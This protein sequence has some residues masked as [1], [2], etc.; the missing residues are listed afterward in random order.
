MDPA[1]QG[2]VGFGAFKLDARGGELRKGKQRLHLPPQPFKVLSLLVSRAGELV[3]REELQH[4]L[5]N[6]E[7]F[8]DFEQG[9]NVCIR[10]IRTVLND[11][12]EAPRFVET[13]PRRGYRFIGRHVRTYPRPAVINSVVVL[14]FE[15]CSED[16]ELDYL[17]QGIAESLINSLS[18]LPGL[19][20][21]SRGMAFRYKGASDLSTVRQELN[22][23]AVVTGKVI[24]QC[25]SIS[26]QAELTDLANQS[27]LWGGQYHRR[28]PAD[29]FK[30]Q[31]EISR[32]ICQGMRL[33]LSGDVKKRLRKRCT[34]DPEAYELYLK[35]RYC[36][37][38]R[39]AEELRKG[40][41]YFRKAIDRDPNYALAY[42]GLADS[43][44]LLGS[45]TYGTLSAKTAMSEAKTTAMKALAIDDTLAEAHTALAFVKFRFDWTWADAESEF[46]QAIKLNPR[47]VRAHHWY[48]LFLAAMSRHDGAAE[49]IKEARRLDPLALTVSTAEGRIL[50]FAREYDRAIEQF[51]KILELDPNFIAAHFDLGATYRAK[52]MFKEAIA[53]FEICVARSGGSPIYV[54]AVAEAHGRWG[55]RGKALKI[56]G[57]LQQASSKRYVSP[58][59]ISLI[60]AGLGDKDEA[61]AWLERAYEQRD[62]TLVWSKVAPECDSLRSDPRFQ[63][64]LRRMNLSN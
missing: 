43:F 31:D 2:V 3:T 59:D 10:Q 54:A 47:Y 55:N 23:Q 45:G 7:T 35:G 44:T 24:S 21:V 34:Q 22:V 39:S 18:L 62:A 36:A 57:Q 16:S 46:Q 49:K 17:C 56:L 37:E 63:D 8:V 19:M 12:A 53:E 13:V 32:E 20:V 58:G 5:W 25:H 64:L 15:N 26:V 48:A 1:L 41:E 38:K 4:Q 30:L 42:A 27:Q 9:L 52:S 50:H 11:C 60:Y 61:F 51:R 28:E 40:I 6:G 33:R 29:I 14:P